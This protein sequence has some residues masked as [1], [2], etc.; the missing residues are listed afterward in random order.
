MTDERKDA[1][2]K[3]IA[4]DADLIDTVHDLMVLAVREML[5]DDSHEHA[6]AF[7]ETLLKAFEMYGLTVEKKQ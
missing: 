2:D 3:L 5:T 4:Q 1:M 7:A 6:G